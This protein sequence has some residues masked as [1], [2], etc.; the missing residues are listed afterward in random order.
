[1]KRY[2]LYIVSI[3][4]LLLSCQ[5]STESVGKTYTAQLVANEI[6]TPKLLDSIQAQIYDAFVKGM[7]N[8]SD[9]PLS[10]MNN[11]L[12]ELYEQ[13]PNKLIHY[14]QAYLSYY[15]AI[16]HLQMDQEKA[17]EK[18]VDSGIELLEDMPKKN[19]EDYA[20]LA[21]MESFSLQFKSAVKLPFISGDVKDHAEKSKQLNPDNPRAY[22]VLGSNDFYTPEKYGGGKKV[23]QYLKQA[24]KLPE[25]EQP[26]SYLP[27]W[28]VEESYE[29]LIKYYIKKEE[30]DNAK[31]YFSEAQEKY[32]DNYRIKEMAPKLVG[33]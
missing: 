4:V 7:I 2:Y 19:S 8:K 3:A 9:E 17:S 33:K 27:S 29:L 26:N 22:Y 21:M 6:S 32:P 10:A 23:E 15:D 13:S 16:F 11:E 25:Q 1:V 31:Q 5:F 20:L 28:G 18:A 30:W 12:E 24:I 14:W